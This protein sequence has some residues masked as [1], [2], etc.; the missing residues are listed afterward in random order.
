[1]TG[2]GVIEIYEEIEA[3]GNKKAKI[4]VIPADRWYPIVSEKDE[5]EI[6]ANAIIHCYKLKD[7]EYINRI[8]I[9][10]K[11]YNLYLAVH[12]KESKIKVCIVTG[13]QI[14]RAH[15]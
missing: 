7:D 4:A 15:V 9:Y 6:V 8:V 11:G 1:M 13:K 10:C 5:S 3:D 14:G 2:N 12:S